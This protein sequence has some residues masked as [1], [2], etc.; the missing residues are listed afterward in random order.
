[1]PS[2]ADGGAEGLRCAW[3]WRRLE[4][5]PGCRLRWQS[6]RC[7]RSLTSDAPDL[8]PDSLDSQIMVL[9]IVEIVL[10]V[11][12]LIQLLGWAVWG[13]R[14]WRRRWQLREEL[15][16]R[17]SSEAAAA[18]A[19]EGAPL[20]RRAVEGGTAS[21]AGGEG[22]R[23]HADRRSSFLLAEAEAAAEAE[24]EAD[25]A[26]RTEIGA[27]RRRS[28]RGRGKGRPGCSGTPLSSSPRRRRHWPPRNL[29]ARCRWLVITPPRSRRTLLSSPDPFTLSD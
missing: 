1:M 13:G 9:E 19:A 27:R 3:S 26:R 22:R 24:A 20:P 7:G 18:A 15:S 25:P 21:A 8:H 28:G 16:A 29:C 10:A 11:V 14:R 17:A 12:V 4:C 23:T 6:L 5:A 2:R